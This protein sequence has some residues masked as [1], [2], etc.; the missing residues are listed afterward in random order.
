MG[1]CFCA[2]E[3]E[4]GSWQVNK[5]ETRECREESVSKQILKQLRPVG[6]DSPAPRPLKHTPEPVSPLLLKA[7]HRA[8][9][10]L[11]LGLCPLSSLLPK[12]AR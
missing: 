1:L 2:E 10:L 6:P 7:F 5:E 11:C 8:C 12:P 3:G 9:D 4:L